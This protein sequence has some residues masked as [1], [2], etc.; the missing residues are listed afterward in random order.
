MKDP[1]TIIDGSG[2][3]NVTVEVTDEIRELYLSLH[4]VPLPREVKRLQ[5]RDDQGRKVQERVET[6]ITYAGA[7]LRNSVRRAKRWM[8]NRDRAADR[9]A[10]SCSP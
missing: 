10:T 6:H 3:R 9:P 7:H 2:R 1:V 8:L 4:G 5:Q